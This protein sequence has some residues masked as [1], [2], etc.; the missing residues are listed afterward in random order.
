MRVPGHDRDD[1]VRRQ[2][3]WLRIMGSSAVDPIGEL[4]PSLAKPCDDAETQMRLTDTHGA[5]RADC[6]VVFPL[7]SC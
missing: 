3:L 4:D 5:K 6:C 7:G 1:G 2:V